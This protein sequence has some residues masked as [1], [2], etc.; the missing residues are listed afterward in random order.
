MADASKPQASEALP[1][2]FLEQ[3]VHLPET[4]TV[5]I[6]KHQQVPDGWV[7]VAETI[8]E[9]GPGAWPN[10]WILKKPEEIE[11]V[12]DISPVPSNYIKIEKVGSTACPGVWPNAWKIER[13]TSST[14]E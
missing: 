1:A 7:I 9:H 12:C 6:G 13:L 4:T 8:L 2:A 10:G 5:C 3:L 11:T 14:D